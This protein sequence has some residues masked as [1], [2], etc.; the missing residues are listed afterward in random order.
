MIYMIFLQ[1]PKMTIRG[2]R[3]L[4]L[5]FGDWKPVRAFCSRCEDGRTLC[6]LEGG[7]LMT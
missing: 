7:E 4:T 1:V 6:T 5:V 3:T 2:K